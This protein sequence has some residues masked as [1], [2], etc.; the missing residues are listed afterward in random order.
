MK[1]RRSL[2]DMIA[3]SSPRIS[4][5][6]SRDRTDTDTARTQE[7]HRKPAPLERPAR[8]G[9]LIRLRQQFRREATERCDRRSGDRRLRVLA[10][11]LV[12]SRSARPDE[13][14]NTLQTE[15]EQRG[16]AMGARFHDVAVPV[17]TTCLPGSGAGCG[18]YTPPWKRPGWGEVERLIRGGFADG[19]IVLDRHNISSD[20]DEYRAVI[21]ELG[22]RYQA[23]IHLVIPEELSGPT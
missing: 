16:Y 9:E 17:T 4:L 21:K 19:V 15:A 1:T 11:S 14:W 8:S 3:V 12:L 5:M 2:G 20:D 7:W 18:V 10:Y 6:G 23:F 13:D 22:E